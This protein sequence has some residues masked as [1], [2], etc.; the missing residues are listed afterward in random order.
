MTKIRHFVLFFFCLALGT[1]SAQSGKQARDCRDYKVKGGCV[2]RAQAYIDNAYPTDSYRYNLEI[3]KTPKDRYQWDFTL[4]QATDYHFTGIVGGSYNPIEGSSRKAIIHPIL[5]QYD[6]LEERVTFTNLEV[7][8]ILPD[9]EWSELP[10]EDPLMAVTPRYLNLKK[11]ITLTTPSGISITL[12]AQG[13][14]TLDKVFRMF[15]GNANALFIRIKTSPNEREVSLPSSPLYKKH[16]K[17]VRI[18]L[19]CAL[20]YH[21]GYFMADNTYDTISIS[22]KDLKTVTHL[23]SLTLIIRQRIDLKSIPISLSVPVSRN[24]RK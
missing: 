17:P 5:H 4:D 7:G 14:E 10:G 19:D 6:T 21:M 11:P 9:T 3:I 22:M 20:P 8:P 12:P 23:D 24:G 16:K 1:A 15:N 2:L 13:S 18:A